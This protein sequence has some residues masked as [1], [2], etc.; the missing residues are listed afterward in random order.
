MYVFFV[1][2]FTVSYITMSTTRITT[3]PTTLPATTTRKFLFVLLLFVCYKC[4]R[5]GVFCYRC[6]AAVLISER[7]LL[8][9]T[10]F[11]PPPPPPPPTPLY[12]LSTL[13]KQHINI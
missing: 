9:E 6:Q 3:T 2:Y 11:L 5:S 10:N 8:Y 7:K 1:Y 13:N 4:F 12:Y